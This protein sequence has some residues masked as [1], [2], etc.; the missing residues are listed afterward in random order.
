MRRRWFLAL[1][2]VPIA[3]QTVT[4]PMEPP[5]SS[6]N[7]P[8]PEPEKPKVTCPLGHED[9]QNT[10]YYIPMDP[11]DLPPVDGSAVLHQ[12]RRPVSV[13]KKCGVIF[14]LNATLGSN[15]TSE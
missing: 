7:G 4:I 6:P 5:V 3:A 14:D 1:L 11:Q 8:A 15:S 12:W 10:G 2:G 9:M 13:C